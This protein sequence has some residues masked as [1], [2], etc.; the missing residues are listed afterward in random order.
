M[1]IKVDDYDGAEVKKDYKRFL[2]RFP[3]SMV[4]AKAQTKLAK[5][6]KQEFEKNLKSATKIRKMTSIKKVEGLTEEQSREITDLYKDKEKMGQSLKKLHDDAIASY[7][8]K[9]YTAN[10]KAKEAILRILKE[11][12]DNNNYKVSISYR[13]F[14]IG[15]KKTYYGPRSPFAGKFS[16]GRKCEPI[17]PSFTS[18]RNATREKVITK[19]IQA[20]FQNITTNDILEFVPSKGDI[21]LKISYIIKPMNMIYQFKKSSELYKKFYKGLV[22]HWT[23]GIYVKGKEIYKFR[24]KT[25]P[26]IRFKVRYYRYRS[27][28][29]YNY[30]RGSSISATTFYDK[31]AE[32]IF[33]IFYKQLTKHFGMK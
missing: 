9:S 24:Q 22:F 21:Q 2:R 26:P 23:V 17:A 15:L 4:K 28:Y 25:E 12:R 31:M 8:R 19:K 7:K 14:T 5:I 1:N 29:S 27:K 3:N 30:D 20:A 11:S 13:R 18:A 32:E 10:P 16:K 33:E 6:Y